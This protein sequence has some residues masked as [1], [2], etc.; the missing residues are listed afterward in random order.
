MADPRP[1]FATG[2]SPLA[3][4]TGP[5]RPGGPCG[6]RFI[7]ACA[8]NGPPSS[9][10][11]SHGA[12][13]PRLRGERRSAAAWEV[14]AAGSS[15]LARGTDERDLLLRVQVRFIPA[16]AG[17]GPCRSGRWKIEPVHPRL[18][19]ERSVSYFWAGMGSGSSPLAR[20]T[21]LA[22]GHG[23]LR[24][25]FI[26][27]C[28][29]NGSTSL[30][31][32]GTRAVHP[33]LRGERA[34]ELGPE[35]AGVGSSPLARGTGPAS[36]RFVR[37]GRFI[38]A[39]AGNG[40]GICSSRKS[41]SV[42]PRLR[43]ER[44]AVHARSSAAG[45]S[46]P[47]ARGTGRCTEGSPRGSRFIPACAGNGTIVKPEH[48]KLPVH[49]RLR[50]ERRPRPTRP[51]LRSGSSPLAR[52]TDVHGGRGPRSHRFIPACAG[53]GLSSNPL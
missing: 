5:R 38:P 11:S 53:N 3:R 37:A 4:G 31:L 32:P 36:A 13:H 20:G 45:G 6:V 27:A 14:A 40:T 17:N 7:P 50:G 25:R 29:G 23:H 28:A 2:S 43:G 35:V 47:L 49:P 30:D 48:G 9:R 42:H 22:P 1:P 44:F 16:C 39:C 10:R 41:L 19:G 51:R 52:G 33:R 46:S 18:R 12:V 34:A 26:P 24:H 15:P 8:G 21:D